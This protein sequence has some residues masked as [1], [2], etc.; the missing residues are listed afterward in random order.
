MVKIELSHHLKTERRNKYSKSPTVDRLAAV[1]T[2]NLLQQTQNH[3][4]ASYLRRCSVIFREGLASWWT[5]SSLPPYLPACL[6]PSACSIQL[7]NELLHQIAPSSRK[8]Y[9][10]SRFT[11]EFWVFAGPASHK[12]MSSFQI[13][14]NRWS[15]SSPGTIKAPLQVFGC[16]KVTVLREHSSCIQ[17]FTACS[18][19]CKLTD[20]WMKSFDKVVIK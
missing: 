10:R 4:L 5:P 18:T 12:L 17:G 11:S 20:P 13:P 2:N 15:T 16:S 3:C 9:Y 7:Q 14:E 19:H 1:K 8:F 6:P